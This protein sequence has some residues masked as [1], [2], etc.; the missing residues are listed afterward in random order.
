M[1]GH[2]LLSPSSA[3]RWLHCTR[4]PRF[5]AQ[6]PDSAGAAAAE[7]TL[8]HALGELKVRHQAAK[9]LTRADYQTAAAKLREHPLY[10]AEMERCTDAYADFVD[11]TALGYPARPYIAVEQSLP[12]DDWIVEGAGT[13][14]CII[15][16]GGQLDIIDLKYGKGVPVS[17]EGNPQMRLYA[18]GALKR[19]GQI[20]RID[21]VR[22]T[23]FQPRLESVTSE[24]LSREALEDW[25]ERCKTVARTAYAGEGEFTPGDWCRFCRGKGACRAYAGKVLAVGRLKSPPEG[26]TPEELSRALTEGAALSQWYDGVKEYA[27]SLTL[28]GTEIPGWKAVEGRSIRKFRDPEKALDA[29][30]AA[31]YEEALLYDRK[32]KT[33]A[34]L[35]SLT[36][37][38]AFEA[39]LGPLV[40]RP[41]GAPALVP[42]S[43]KREPYA[44]NDPQQAFTPITD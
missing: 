19:Y 18:L 16:G 11:E 24:T 26:M 42:A 28:G 2:A 36:G 35:E 10:T 5:E 9:T 15:L 43:D 13:G 4:A 20:F 44:A 27:L 41:Q 1:T 31:G 25:G 33:L 7:G 14:D 3:H 40:V 34:Q 22:M 23:I 6:F 8:A 37:K 21:A 29:L 12:L 17:A 39:I 30:R 32:P 38:K